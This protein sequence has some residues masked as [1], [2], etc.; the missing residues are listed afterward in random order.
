ME[1]AESILVVILASFLAIFLVLGIVL[2]IKLIQIAN[3]IKRISEKAEK[4]VDRAESV[5][6]FFQKASGSFAVGRLISHL[7][8]SVLHRE[9]KNSKKGK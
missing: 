9:E 2:V 4:V 3:Q 6:E 7:A 1:N 8:N 5:G